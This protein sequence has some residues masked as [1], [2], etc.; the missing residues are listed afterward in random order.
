MPPSFTAAR[1][2]NNLPN[3]AIVPIHAV[4]VPARA[5]AFVNFVNKSPSP[6]HAVFEI[7]KQ[8][9]GSGFTELS[10]EDNW[11][12]LMPPGR[13]FCTRNATSLVAWVVGKAFSTDTG[14][15][16]ITAAHTDSPCLKVKPLSKRVSEG[17]QMVG[18][19]A[20]GGLLG[21]TWFD[22][23]LSVAGRI[24]VDK[25]DGTTAMHLTNVPRPILRV[26]SLAIHLNRTANEAFKLNM[27]QHMSALLKSEAMAALDALEATRAATAEAASL[28]AAAA[29]AASSA[30]AAASSSPSAHGAPAPCVPAAGRHHSRLM[31]LLAENS[32]PADVS[33]EDIV[34]LDL[35]IYDTSPAAVGG[36]DFEFILSARLDNLLMS[37]ACI[38]SLLDSL[39][40]ADGSAGGAPEDGVVR[41]VAL[42]DN[43]EVG[44]GSIAG[45]G[46][47]LMESVLRR[48]CEGFRPEGASLE[49]AVAGVTRRSLLVS[50][51]MAH[52]AHPNYPEKHESLHRP[53][54]NGGLV[55]KHNTNQRYATNVVT[56][57][58]LRKVADSCGMPIQEFVIRQDMG[59][60]STIGPILATSLGMRTVDVGVAQ[61]AM[62]SCREMCGSHDL[63]ATIAIFNQL[64]QQWG[65]LSSS[66]VRTDSL[67]KS[68]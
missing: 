41:A 33:A 32:D 26:P 12:D 25:P 56:A 65:D 58:A 24:L 53:R 18:T 1:R 14:S 16:V 49:G 36:P 62:H 64:Y 60:G 39:S 11:I 5:Q 48:V 31:D 40:A 51:D 20:Y 13:Y 27:E 47:N 30:G 66:I 37:H 54:M 7:A 35:C 46:S 28:P 21:Y 55:V 59:C 45:A 34:D 68:P 9:K 43:E 2:S 57:T 4:S 50:A 3:A 22:R 38:E 52:A 17:L 10:E 23:D 67:T 42:F 19:E 29:A 63:E 15:F 44:S 61:L 6:Y 8:L